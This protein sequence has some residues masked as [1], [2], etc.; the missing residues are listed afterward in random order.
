MT[1]AWNPHDNQFCSRVYGVVLNTKSIDESAQAPTRRDEM[2]QHLHTHRER[3]HSPSDLVTPDITAPDIAGIARA[4][5]F[6]SGGIL[7]DRSS[8]EVFADRFVET[9]ARPSCSR[10]AVISNLRGGD[11]G[12][13]SDGK[14]GGE[15]LHG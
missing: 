15:E 12:Q 8:A 13:A 4:W 10:I 6:P 3:D 5:E 14:N 2:R 7:L 9:Q 1:G 11:G